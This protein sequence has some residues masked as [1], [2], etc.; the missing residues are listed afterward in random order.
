[1]A[2]IEGSQEH[3]DLPAK[4]RTMRRLRTVPGAEWQDSVGPT[5][6][7]TLE[8]VKARAVR[9]VVVLTGR[10]FFL[11]ILSFAAWIFLSIFLDA[12]EIGLFFIV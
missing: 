1:M 2:E 5:D 6:E 12:K 10:T 9:G 7:I 3:L 11:Q 8:T 4:N